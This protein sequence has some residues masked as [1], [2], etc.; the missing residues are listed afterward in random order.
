[1]SPAPA[2]SFR[3]EGL[4]RGRRTLRLVSALVQ[5]SIL[6]F[7]VMVF[8]EQAGSLLSDGQ[9]TWG[10]RRV[11]G[12]TALVSIGGCVLAAWAAG[13]LIAVFG[14]LFDAL[15]DG[16]EASWRTVQLIETQVVPALNRIALA[17][18]DETRRPEPPLKEKRR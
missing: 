18:E 13:R 14:D 9:F 4:R 15:A 1:M 16:A 7:G 11:M 17:L 12:L 10:E 2:G 8:L 3:Y 5:S 6:L